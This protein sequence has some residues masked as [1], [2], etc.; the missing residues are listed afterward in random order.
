MFFF[1]GFEL[2]TPTPNKPFVLATRCSR[3]MA[4]EQYMRGFG[5]Y[6]ESEAVTCLPPAPATTPI[7]SI[8]GAWSSPER[9]DHASKMPTWTLRRATQWFCFHSP[10]EPK[11][12]QLALSHQA[13][14]VTSAVCT[15]PALQKSH[16]QG[17]ANST[18]S[19]L[20]IQSVD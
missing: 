3:S 7:F 13:L 17:R 1:I 16:P 18:E 6:F 14:G 11:P 19:T 15:C 8:A 2:E 10:P 12:A 4:A 9:S 20:D 5:N